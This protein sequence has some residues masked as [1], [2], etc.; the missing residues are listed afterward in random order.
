MLSKEKK[1]KEM[2]Y[3]KYSFYSSLLWIFYIFTSL[4]LFSKSHK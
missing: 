4:E 3:C 1:K 2:L